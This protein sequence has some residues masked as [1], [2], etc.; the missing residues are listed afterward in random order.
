[1]FYLL[2]FLMIRRPPRSTQSR[3]SAASDVYKRQALAEYSAFVWMPLALLAFHKLAD[4]FSLRRL[5]AAGL[6]YG[7]LWLTHNPTGLTFTPVLAAYVLWR[8]LAR[9]APWG[10]QLRRAGG[11][12]AAS[13]LG[14]GIAA[15]LLVPNLL[16]RGY[17]NLS[18]I[19]I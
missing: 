19:H 1:M 15:A 3:S 8:L 18:L 9:P 11:A 16:E 17:I 6:A 2:F 5:G 12:L 4:G 10:E 13:I 14:L 7:A